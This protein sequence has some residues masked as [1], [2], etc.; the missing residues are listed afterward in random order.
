[1]KNPEQSPAP[2]QNDSAK[3]LSGKAKKELRSANKRRQRKSSSAGRT[4]LII[5]VAAVVL[6]ILDSFSWNSGGMN[7]IYTMIIII[8]A[9]IALAVTFISSRS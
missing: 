4:S 3:K 2:E 6:I 7:G 9:V 8:V 5:I 1:M